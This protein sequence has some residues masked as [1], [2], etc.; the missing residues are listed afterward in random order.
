MEEIIKLLWIINQIIRPDRSSDVS[1]IASNL[2]NVTVTEVLKYNKI[3]S[4]VHPNGKLNHKCIASFRNLKNAAS[5]GS[6]VIF[7]QEKNGISY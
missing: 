7:L 2:T 5:Q 6:Y 1:D 3:V 4:K